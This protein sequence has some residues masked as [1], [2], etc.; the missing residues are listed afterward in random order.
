MFTDND[1]S[2]L[3]IKVGQKNYLV[4]RQQRSRLGAY[5]HDKKLPVSDHGTYRDVVPADY[6]YG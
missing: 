2:F 1:S 4:A 3:T 5:G 6:T